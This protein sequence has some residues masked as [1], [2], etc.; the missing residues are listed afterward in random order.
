MEDALFDGD[1]SDR[2]IQGK[3]E[4]TLK[5]L[6]SSWERAIMAETRKESI[7]SAIVCF[8]FVF[9]LQS[10]VRLFFE[11]GEGYHRW[12][13]SKKSNTISAVI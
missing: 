12:G 6:N 9:D 3:V 4:N 8:T 1:Q 5:L 11:N 7:G 2:D 13:N 10:L